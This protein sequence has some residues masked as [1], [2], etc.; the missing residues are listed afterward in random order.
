MTTIDLPLV[1]LDAV[2]KPIRDELDAVWAEVTSS[3]SFI[4]GPQ[5]E[6]FEQQWAEF[7]GTADA[8][9]VGNGTEALEL[10]LRGLDIG[11]ESE[12]IVP[13]S[14][15]IATA[16]AVVAAGAKPIF[17]DVDPQSLL[18]TAD[19]L[20]SALSPRTAAVIVVHLYGNLVET[21]AMRQVASAAGIF[22]IEDAA[23]AHG[24][25]SAG[26]RA[27]SLGHAAGFSHYPSKNLGA[28][29]DGGTIT[30]DDQTL[31]RRIRQ[32]RNHGRANQSE[33]RYEVIGRTGRL[34][35]L[36][37]AILSTKLPHLDAV[38][39]ERRR[40]V[41]MYDEL[42]PESMPRIRTDQPDQAAPHL[43]VVRC[44][45]R[46]RV[47]DALSAAGIGSGIHYPD[48]VPR[49]PAFGGRLGFPVAEAAADS[50][51]SLP[52]WSGMSREDVI[53]VCSVLNSTDGVA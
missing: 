33:T 1:S 25:G 42:L 24:A 45:D 39:L 8:I 7:C 31:A 44:S 20:R 30:S 37:A 12:V 26:N 32:L 10:I 6:R 11:P 29:G 22:V 21:E 36:Q 46:D 50:M 9:G 15:Y 35:S 34:D 51:V 52:L 40:V 43:C 38:N 23:Q 47:R 2:N 4:L 27:G 41:A 17:T 13:A 53:R 28:F 14:T 3:N 19:H 5:L 48:P 16:A 18:M 49:T